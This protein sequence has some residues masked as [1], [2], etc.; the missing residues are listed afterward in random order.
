[1]KKLWIVKQILLLS[2]LGSSW[3]TVWSNFIKR[4][5]NQ[6]TRA[7]NT[8]T[9]INISSSFVEIFRLRCNVKTQLSDTVWSVC[10]LTCQHTHFKVH[11][12]FIYNNNKGKRLHYR[13][14][15]KY[16]ICCYFQKKPLLIVPRSSQKV[17][18]SSWQKKSLLSY[19]WIC[20]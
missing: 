8:T 19:I 14:C 13:L 12:C 5:F 2:T 1:M 15:E 18:H 4:C 20:D 7:K 11:L 10:G 6:P 3:R 17:G 16:F 9:V